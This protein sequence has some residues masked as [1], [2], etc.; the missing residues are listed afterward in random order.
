MIAKVL[1][2]AQSE[3]D[4]VQRQVKISSILY[5]DEPPSDLKEKEIKMVEDAVISHLIIGPKVSADK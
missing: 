1:E 5:G 2:E 3:E 4:R